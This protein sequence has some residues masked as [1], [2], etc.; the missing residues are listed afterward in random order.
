MSRTPTWLLEFKRKVH[1]QTG[2]DGIIEKILDVVGQN[3]K[4]CVEFGAWDGLFLMNTRYLI[5]AKEY[6]AILIEADKRKYRDLQRNYSHLKTVTTLNRLVGFN[7][8]EGLDE[9]LKA[10]SIPHDFD[11]L[12]IDVDGNDYH[13]W[14]AVADYVPK[15]VVIEFNPTIPTHVHFVQPA[16]ASVSQGASLLSLVDLGKEKGYEL[17]CALSFNAFFVRRE[18]FPKFEIEDNSPDTLR[19][20][21]DGITYL[22]SGYDGRIFLRGN[23]RLPWHEVSLSERRLQQ[24]PRFLRAH[25]EHYSYAQRIAFALY[26]MSHDPEGLRSGVRKWIHEKMKS[27]RKP[28]PGN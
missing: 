12:S 25:R 1:S 14:K 7:E 28:S 5:E 8:S 4:W 22:F 23:L 13:I 26:R 11:L 2:E 6:S 16:D 15:V 20:D 3:D 27:L 10:T 19:T 24:L 18:F 17:V 21:V 9:L